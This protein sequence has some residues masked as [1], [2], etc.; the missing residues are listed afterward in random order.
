M[1]PS[2]GRVAV[3]GLGLMGASLAMALDR[4][5][6]RVRGVEVDPAARAFL[7]GRLPGVAVFPAVEAAAL[8]GAEV[9]VLA[10]P[11]A[12]LAPVAAAVAVHLPPAAVVTDLTSVKAPALERMLEHLPARRV[13]GGH[14]MAGRTSAGPYASDPDLFHG[15]PWAVVAPKGAEAS[16]AAAVRDLARL[17]GARPVD[18]DAE[19]HDR[20]VA[21]VSHLPYLL[22]GA[23]ARAVAELGAGAPVEALVGPGLEGMLRLAAQPAW[24]D[25]VCAHNRAHLAPALAALEAALAPVQEAL[26]AADAGALRALGEAGRRA[27]ERLLG[28]AQPS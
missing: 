27:H 5:G 18:L 12:A 4:R 16:A 6:V 1:S 17:V 25:D 28:R 8:E 13:V 24:M 11:L 14:P 21:A 3:V 22:S 23:L 7:A 15:R 10:V 2:P 26:A 19:G 9:V 20:A